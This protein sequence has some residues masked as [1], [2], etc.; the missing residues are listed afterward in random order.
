MR[1][2]F[3]DHI[4]DSRVLP[5][6]ASKSMALDATARGGRFHKERIGFLSVQTFAGN[7]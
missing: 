3:I 1:G 2:E 6:A 5:V 7:P 4:L